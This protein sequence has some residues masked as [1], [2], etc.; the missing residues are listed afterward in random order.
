MDAELKTVLETFEA[1]GRYDYWA[2]QVQLQHCS[3]AMWLWE[4]AGV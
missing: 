3:W 4:D 1:K 2:E